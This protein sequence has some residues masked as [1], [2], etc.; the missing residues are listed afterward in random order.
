MKFIKLSQVI[1][2]EDRDDMSTGEDD[3]MEDANLQGGR[4]DVTLPVLVPIWNDVVRTIVKRKGDRV[5]SR[6]VFMNGS[7]IPVS[8]TIE[9][10]EA[11]ISGL[12]VITDQRNG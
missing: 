4:V 1:G 5:G 10:I 11:L 12:P 7:A 8:E 6:I 2:Q 9:Q 3:G